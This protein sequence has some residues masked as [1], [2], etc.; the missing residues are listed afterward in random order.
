MYYFVDFDRTLFN[1]D[2]FK[3]ALTKPSFSDLRMQLKLIRH[4][5]LNPESHGK[6][7]GILNRM[8]GTYLSHRRFS[9]SQ[10]ELGTYLYPDARE[11]L[12][13][14]AEH[15]TVVTYGVQA[16]ITAKV[17]NAL[18]NVPLKNI[19]YTS[20]KKG[21]TIHRLSQEIDGPAAFIDDMPFQLESVGKW[22]PV[23]KLY[24][25]RRDGKSGTGKWP[26]IRSFEDL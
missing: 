22:C 1:T 9:F 10:D 15:T 6:R 20:R 23:V 4:E 18:T 13:Q 14:H 11:F 5:F 16:F 8:V 24:E 2:A 7:M 21:R 26:V 19:V 12:K 17:T 25:I 3:E